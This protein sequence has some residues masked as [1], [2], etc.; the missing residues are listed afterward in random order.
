MGN[1]LT[2]VPESM[3]TFVAT[4]VGSIFPQPDAESVWTRP[5]QVGQQLEP[6]FPQA[7]AVLASAAHELLAFAVVPQAHWTQM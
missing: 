3:A 1:L 6:R 5:Q 4:L 2:C 7:A